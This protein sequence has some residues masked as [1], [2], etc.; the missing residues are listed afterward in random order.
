MLISSNWDK[1]LRLFKFSG[2][3][4]TF[5]P[6]FVLFFYR[7]LPMQNIFGHNRFVFVNRFSIFLLH[8]LRQ[9][10]AVFDCGTLRRIFSVFLNVILTFQLKEHLTK[11]C[12]RRHTYVQK[13]RIKSQ[14][15]ECFDTQLL[16]TNESSKYY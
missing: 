4:I 13:I 2:K 16:L 6:C 1:I 5:L 3:V 11:L 14:H 15:I 7:K 8:I 12:L 9:I 10:D